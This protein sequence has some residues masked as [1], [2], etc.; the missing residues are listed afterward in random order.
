MLQKADA[1]LLV[2]AQLF[3]KAI[4]NHNAMVLSKSLFAQNFGFASR[5]QAR[6]FFLLGAKA[7]TWAL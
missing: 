6:N 4:Q 1:Y 7:E 5:F 3:I 2:L